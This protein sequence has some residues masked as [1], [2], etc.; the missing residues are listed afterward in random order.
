MEDRIQN[1]QET[2]KCLVTH[3]CNLGYTECASCN[4]CV[5][6]GR[7]TAQC[8]NC[9]SDE[10]LCSECTT[11]CLTCE[12]T[13]CLKDYEE[14]FTKCD[15]CQAEKCDSD[16]MQLCD[17]C[18]KSYCHSCFEVEF[19][20]KNCG[21][22]VCDNCLV[23]TCSRLSEYCG[24]CHLKSC[25]VC[26]ASQYFRYLPS[27]VQTEMYMLLLVYTRFET[28]T[29]IPPKYVNQIIFRYVIPTIL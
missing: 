19:Q 26:W 4:K 1:Q 10:D 18:Q 8:Y 13:Y 15:I 3:L 21:V 20:C 25:D 27:T 5:R 6:H 12:E 24:E 17:T 23:K 16:D 9:A 7:D 29:L 11:Y 2:I 14:H 22:W 28:K